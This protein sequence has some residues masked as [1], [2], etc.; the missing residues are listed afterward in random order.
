MSAPEEINF[1][2]HSLGIAGDMLIGLVTGICIDIV[3]TYLHN[4]VGWPFLATII[5]QLVLIII[6]LYI[7]KRYG[8]WKNENNYGVLF[9]AFLIAPQHNLYLLFNY[10]TNKKSET[11][12]HIQL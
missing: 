11:I 12:P 7:E 1:V 3:C 2:R 8:Y 4:T 6:A 9:T 10:I 5:L